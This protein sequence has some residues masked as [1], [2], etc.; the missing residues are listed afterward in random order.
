MDTDISFEHQAPVA[1]LAVFALDYLKHASWFPWINGNSE[2]LN[3]LVSLA[4]ACGTAAG[5]KVLS[6]DY[7]HGWVIAVPPLQ[8][9]IDTLMHAATQ[10]GGQELLHKMLGNHSMNKEML[11]QLTA[12]TNKFSQFPLQGGSS[13]EAEK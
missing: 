9:I 3:R 11:Q 13:V 8:V 1:V 7:Q 10:F 4:V 5:L 2:K 12:L 6:G